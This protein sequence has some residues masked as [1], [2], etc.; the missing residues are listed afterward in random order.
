MLYT[1]IIHFLIEV[2]LNTLIIWRI[3]TMQG[4]N[5]TSTWDAVTSVLVT[6]GTYYV[7][8]WLPCGVWFV[9]DIANPHIP[10]VEWAA[11]RYLLLHTSKV[12]RDSKYASHTVL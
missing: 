9:W 10:I 7:L 12:Q 8:C 11:L 4:A 2:P 5:Q 6:I 3:S 1:I